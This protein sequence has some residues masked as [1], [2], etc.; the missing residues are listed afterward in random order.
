MSLK[1]AH[2]LL[3]VI[4]VCLFNFSKSTEL[5]FEL[6]DSAKECFHQEVQK[7][8]SVTLE[9]QVIT[10]GQ[11]DVDVSLKDPK[12][13]IIYNVVKMQFDSNTFTAEHTGV[14]VVCFSNE[15]STFSHK[16]I[17][18]DF[19]VG[20][21]QPLPGIGEHVTV[22]TQLETSAQ[23]IHK[24]L[25][26]IIDFQTH[27]RLREAQGRKRAE[28]LNERVL[29]WSVMETIAIVVIGIG[30]VLVLKNFFTDKK[31]YTSLTNY[32]S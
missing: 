26:T 28:D 4:V 22:M 7:N 15:F 31:P 2:E 17:Y 24:S 13:N 19:Q 20:D 21:E 30:Q 11:Y 12:N 5:T 29:W 18:F 25:N 14:Y 8:T 23:E 16:L 10:G 6:P 32:K 3:L 27:H 9:Y 1:T